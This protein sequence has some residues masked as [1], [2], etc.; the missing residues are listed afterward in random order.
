[1]VAVKEYDNSSDGSKPVTPGTESFGDTTM[2]EA[3]KTD[4]VSTKPDENEVLR[5]KQE[6]L[7]AQSKI[8]RMDQELSQTRITKHTL[9]Q[10]L[11]PPSEVDFPMRGEVTEQTITSLQSALNASMRPP[12]GRGDSWVVREDSH[13]DSSEGLSVGAYNRSGGIW[14]DPAKIGF[15][16]ALPSP[17]QPQFTASPMNW[18]PEP[19][20]PWFTR[21]GTT[22]ELG[23]QYQHP[24]PHRPMTGQQMHGLN[25]GG[26]FGNDLPSFPTN[27]TIRHNQAGRLGTTYGTRN[28]GFGGFPPNSGPSDTMGSQTSSS[29]PPTPVFPGPIG[30]Q[31]RPIGTPL[32]PT[33]PEFNTSHETSNNP[34]NA[35][36]RHPL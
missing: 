13:S 33:A 34:W 25:E 15:N 6:L 18:T 7:A 8:A 20:R 28:N 26:R 3:S 24:Q 23:P 1:M 14:N 2:P 21:V 31:P 4:A 29:Y 32:S 16:N 9:D 17:T 35:S 5:L 36:V 22:Q 12:L 19:T 27:G 11:G 30:Y 10:A